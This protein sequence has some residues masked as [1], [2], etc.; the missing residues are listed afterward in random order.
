LS[1]NMK[2]SVL[3]EKDQLSVDFSNLLFHKGE[4][5]PAWSP[6]ITSL[7]PGKLV[8]SWSNRGF[9]NLCSA[10]DQAVLVIYNSVKERYMWLEKTAKRSDEQVTLDLSKSFIG[11]KLHCYLSFFSKER[12]LASSNQYLGEIVV[13]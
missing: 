7:D 5:F 1:Y 10:M 11:D 3:Q 6:K 8:F 12:N 4:L 13:S 9:N 2:N